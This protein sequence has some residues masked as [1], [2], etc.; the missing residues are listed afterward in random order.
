MTIDGDV[1]EIEL[2]M[3]LDDVC[4]LK[5]FVATRLKYIEEIIFVGGDEEFATSSLFSLLF[6]IKKTKPSIKIP[7]IDEELFTFK[8]FGKVYWKT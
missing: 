3:E 6:S 2:D 4:E 5:E 8:N 7:L 1:L